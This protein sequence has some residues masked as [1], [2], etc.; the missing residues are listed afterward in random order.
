MRKKE[1]RHL[2]KTKS[3]TYIHKECTAMIK[4]AHD[5]RENGNFQLINNEP[6]IFPTNCKFFQ[7]IVVADV[8]PQP[9]GPTFKSQAVQGM[10]ISRQS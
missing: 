10:P 4:T 2:P 9:V 7:G 8:S 3:A 6:N 1:I 5:V